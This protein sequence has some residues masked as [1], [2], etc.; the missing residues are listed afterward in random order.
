MRLAVTVGGIGVLISCMSAPVLSRPQASDTTRVPLPDPVATHDLPRAMAEL[1]RARTAAAQDQHAEAIR[2]YRRALALYPPLSNDIGVELGHQ[3]TWS[4]QPDSAMMWYRTYLDHHPDDAD[5]WVG[6][7]R[8]ESWRDDLDEA[9][10]LYDRALAADSEN[11][12]AAR[13]KA[14][15]VNWSGRHRA[16]A[17][18]YR[19]I[20]AAHP[21]DTASLAGLAQAQRWMGRPDRTLALAD[22][23]A[24]ALDDIAG[25]IARERAPTVSYTFERNHDSDD[26][27]RRYHTV[28]AGFSPDVMTRVSGVYGHANFEQPARPDVS[29]NTIDGVLERRFSEALTAT[30]NAGY[31]WNSYDRS[32]LGPESFY[33]DDFNLFTFDVYATLTPRDWTRLDFGLSR[34]SVDNPDAIFRGITRTELSA[35]MDKRLRTNLLWVSSAEL[36]WYNDDNSSIGLGTRALWEPLWRAPVDVS[37]RFSSSTGLAYFGFKRTTDNGYYDPR[38]YISI[39]EEVAVAMTFTPRVSARLAGRVSLDK[40]N[41]DD[42]FFTGRFEASAR[43]AMWRGLGLYASYTNSNS[44]LDSRPGY[45]IDGFVVTLEYAF[46]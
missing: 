2:R 15:V 18:L 7:A 12:E 43:W 14:Q 25:E 34:G 21:G 24:P 6:V 11:L 4:D 37:H 27:T 17:S 30:A 32:A 20:L 41:G 5:A 26:I 9:E 39:F 38:Q 8:L 19:N 3:Y 10:R 46:W 1:E 13:G 40:E 23:A 45:E 28:R 42:W 44:R 33:R 35:G 31:E 29:R 22:S 36:A 16:A